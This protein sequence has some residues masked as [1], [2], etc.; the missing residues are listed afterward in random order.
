M[1]ST[2]WDAKRK[3]QELVR[4]NANCIQLNM[5][6]RNL[7]RLFFEVVIKLEF[8]IR[9][10]A[11]VDAALSQT[12]VIDCAIRATPGLIWLP[13]WSFPLCAKASNRRQVL[14]NGTLV[15]SQATADDTGL[16]QCNAQFGDKKLVANVSVSVPRGNS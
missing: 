14:P 4:C 13:H 7:C 15:I 12:I 6:S 1:Q 8:V 11:T 5:F 3:K 2:I 9:P 16:Y 10:P